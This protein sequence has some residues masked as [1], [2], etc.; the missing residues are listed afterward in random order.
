MRKILIVGAGT[1]GL[2]L[3]HGLRAHGYD[4]T[5]ITG[6]SS[7]EIR[8]A[9]PSITQFTLP[10]AM[11]HEQA[12]GLA[13]WEEVAPRITG[14]EL[15]LS[16]PGAA[17][18]M[19]ESAFSTYGV[20]VDR[21]VKIADWLESF[22]DVKEKVDA[23]GNT[24]KVGGKVVIHG[25]TVTDLDYFSRMFDLI[26]LATGH[27]ELGQLLDQGAPD[28][29]VDSRR[30]V[31]QAIIQ[32]VSE[33]SH[34]RWLPVQGAPGSLPGHMPEP[35]LCDYAVV[36]ST[37]QVRAILS[38]VLIDNG[39]QHVLQIVGAP[40]GPMDRWPDRPSPQEQWGLMRDLLCE[41]T[42]HL[43]E[44]LGNASL[45]EEE[46]A[47][48]HVYAPHARNPVGTLP[49]GGL[50]L[51]MADAVVS[52]DDPIA[53]Q[54]ANVSMASANHYLSRILA[55]STAEFT[56]AWM[57]ET[58]AGF[59]EGAP[60]KEFPFAGMGRAAAGLSQVLDQ[61]WSPDAP[62]HL[63]QVLGAAVAHQPVADRFI[64]D[65]DDPRRYAAWL[66]DPDAAHAFLAQ[67]T[68]TA[69]RS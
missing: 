32:G 29:I 51:G 65:L 17:P 3:A 1:S 18:A 33:G 21:R 39:P 58:F 15:I 11:A 16:P 30:T 12:L 55:H 42:P 48:L 2:H 56:K 46:D 6:N 61:I 63:A 8:N 59:W 38:P 14:V 24:I 62:A 34:T 57:E 47:N 41:H 37:P 45:L 19:V 40:G 22:E 10:S 64:G 53:A 4:V 9:R 7:T 20:S 23:Q 66:Y 27:G 69:G 44:R 52:T 31:A 36:A 67:V 60:T 35:V 49:S 13:M 43:N 26:V 25:V 28:H 50:V 54:A 68:A 5:V